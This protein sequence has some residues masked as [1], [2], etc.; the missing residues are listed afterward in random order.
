MNKSWTFSIDD[1]IALYLLHLKGAEALYP[2]SLPPKASLCEQCEKLDFGRLGFYV[3]YTID[4]LRS[5]RSRCGVCKLFWS[6]CQASKATSAHEVQFQMEESTLRM[7]DGTRPIISIVK[8][9]R[10]SNAVDC[11]CVCEYRYS[12]NLLGFD[13]FIPL[14]IGF[15][16]LPASGS[17]LHFEIIRQWLA[18]CDRY[19]RGCVDMKDSPRRL[20]KRLIEVNHS[21]PSMVRLVETGSGTPGNA[22]AMYS[23]VVLSHP[24]GQPPHFST[25]PDDPNDPNLPNTLSR[26]KMGIRIAD[27]PLTFQDAITVTRALGKQYIWIDAICILQGPDGDFRDE[28]K[29]MADIFSGAYCSIAASWAG[30]Q[31][32]GFLKTSPGQDKEAAKRHREVITFQPFGKEPLYLCE[33][34]D[35]FGAHV[36]NGDLNGRGWVLQERALARRT[37]YFTERQTY[38]ECGRGVKCETMTKMNK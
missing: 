26:H 6:A 29:R 12:T 9:P 31:R 15:P 1:E 19:H 37:I 11:E 3:T 24:W 36:L 34:I 5:S 16:K 2:R 30:S 22:G 20:P 27:M 28:S 14:Q 25:V 13:S 10:T 32:D 4:H 23:Y 18:S 17:E 35:D 21:D 38:M 7:A 8:S 33:M